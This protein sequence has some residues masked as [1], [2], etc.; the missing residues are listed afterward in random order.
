[1]ATEKTLKVDGMD[2][3]HCATRLGTA[4]ERAEGVVKAQADHAAGEVRV[5]FHLDRIS[6]DQIKERI[7]A[8]GFGPR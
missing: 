8:S 4:L 7:R 3:A 1:M 2:C 6:E 5:R